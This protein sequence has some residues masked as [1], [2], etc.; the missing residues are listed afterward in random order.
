M[1]AEEVLALHHALW[2]GAD[3]VDYRGQT[4]QIERVD[5][6]TQHFAR[7]K[8]AD[9]NLTVITQNT[10]KPSS[11]TAW[12]LNAPKRYNRRLSWVI[13]DRGG[14]SGKV[15]SWRSDEGPEKAVVFRLKN[16]AKAVLRTPQTSS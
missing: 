7:V 15:Q 4:L 14:F 6:A 3:T 11:N 1:K 10:R 5:N 12:V 8:I 2:G 9:E 16:G 13:E